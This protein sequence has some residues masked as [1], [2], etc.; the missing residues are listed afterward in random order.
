MQKLV[1]VLALAASAASAAPLSPDV[2]ATLQHIS[3]N[4]LRGHLSFIA[5]DLL[6]GRGAPSRGL[7]LAA[8]YIAAQFRRAGLEPLG[9]DG[10]FQTA[11]WTLAE[12][13]LDGFALNV[14]GIALTREQVSF[15]IV[16]AVQGKDAGVV[17]ADYGNLAAL[18]ALGAAVAGKVVVTEIVRKS[19]RSEAEYLAQ[20]KERDAFLARMAALKPLLLLDVERTHPAGNSGG[21]GRLVDPENPPHDS[22]VARVTIHG[23]DAVRWF[24]ALPAGTGGTK[25]SVTLSA[26]RTRPAKLR[27]V[28]GVLR[29]SDPALKDSY[30]MV[31][32]HYDHLGM[33][34]NGTGDTIYNG[35]ND[36]GS[37]TVSVIE[38]A[39]ALAAMKQ[40]PKRSV[41]FM[42]VFGEELGLLGSRY[43]GRHPLVPVAKTVADINLEQV[44]RTD[45]SEGE[46]R[47][48]A[49]MT[50]FD[51]TDMGPIFAQAGEQTGIKV[52]KHAVNSDAY[53]GLSDNQA[54]ADQGV[55][56]HTLCV[57]FE[58]PDY[59][60]VGDHWE[61]VD[62]DNMAK[63]D[64]M[65]ALGVLTIA[66]NAKAPAWNAANTL[67]AK[68]AAARK[69]QE[70]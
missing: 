21:K 12:P 4:S 13:N 49:S 42:T 30:V 15:D 19:V 69:L 28:A 39:D 61:K 14:G 64:R 22:G 1:V 5:S 17:K 2:E 45:S 27:N 63:V 60:G 23:A 32:A 20:V 38:I 34:A 36:D 51:F 26:S 37:G 44:G 52:S 16:P 48:N 29:G 41:V 33:R 66:N 57:S 10:Y 6:E 59:H 18:E 68:Y 46:Q 3:A 54:L 47:N 58:Y 65:V 8:E 24:D 35:A 11:N 67:T 53:F 31:T 9:D 25:V 56:A 7:D 43:Y 55:P 70:K 40:R 62:Y 50:G